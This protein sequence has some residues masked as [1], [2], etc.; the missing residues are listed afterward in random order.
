MTSGYGNREK[1]VLDSCRYHHSVWDSVYSRRVA[2]ESVKVH[3]AILAFVDC[4]RIEGIV[5][6]C[7]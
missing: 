7:D 6:G 1:Q 5:A 2:E 4:V 3:S